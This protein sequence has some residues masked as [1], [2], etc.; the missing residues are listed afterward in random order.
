MDRFVSQAAQA[1]VS[2]S[3]G[4]F[5]LNPARAREKMSNFQL[6]RPG[7]YIGKIVQTANRAGAETVHIRVTR[8]RLTVEFK[9]NAPEL[10][11]TGQVLQ[12]LIATHSLQDSA[13]RHLAVGLSAA[14]SANMKEVRWETPEGSLVLTEDAIKQVPKQAK[15]LRFIAR[16][17]RTMAQWFLGLIYQAEVDFLQ[18]HCWHGYCTLLLD[19]RVQPWPLQRWDAIAGYLDQVG[20]SPTRARLT[21]LETLS[22]EESELWIAPPT[23]ELAASGDSETFHLTAD[24]DREKLGQPLLYRGPLTTERVSVSRA[25]SVQPN[26]DGPG[27]LLLVKDGVLLDPIETQLGHPGVVLMVPAGKLRTDLSEYAVVQDDEFEERLLELRA[28]VSEQTRT[29]STAELQH[30]VRQSNNTR[31]EE[32]LKCWLSNHRLPHVE[33]ISELL[34]QRFP[35]GSLI[36]EPS[37]DQVAAVRKIHSPHLPKE[38]EVLAIY[39]DTLTGTC[40]LGFAITNKRICWKEMLSPPQYVLWQNFDPDTVKVEHNLVCLMRSQIPV[41]LNESVRDCLAGFLVAVGRLALPDAYPLPPEQ[42][43]IIRLALSFFG[44]RS[45]LYY[46]P[47]IPHGKLAAAEKSYSEPL[48]NDQTAL[49]LYDDTLLGGGDTGFIVTNTTL[50]WRNVFAESQSTPLSRMPNS[51]FSRTG[52]GIKIDE[53]ELAVCVEELRTPLIRFLESL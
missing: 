51:K 44:K 12:A 1:G 32:T 9:A 31:I 4:S 50:Y 33:T 8:D 37:P 19:N 23:N 43:R 41:A 24:P 3:S 20:L 49:V 48:P 5:T 26:L 21:I 29:V 6:A 2:D 53:D 10:S 22:P 40:K 46:Y 39:D 14:S 13:L 47:H 11:D 36:R 34:D 45:A 28:W 35:E 38:E 16:K 42:Q 15:V 18:E 52:I 30:I 17:K 25:L 27:T 7:S